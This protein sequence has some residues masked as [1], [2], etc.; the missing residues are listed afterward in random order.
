ML[1]LGLFVLV[2][3]FEGEFGMVVMA[4]KAATE[5]DTASFRWT[6]RSRPERSNCPRARRDEG[7]GEE[8]DG[9]KD[10]SREACTLH[11][12]CLGVK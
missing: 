9:V 1:S 2:R 7:V 3:S 5:G 8:E 10:E 4:S 11:L 6:W 12:S